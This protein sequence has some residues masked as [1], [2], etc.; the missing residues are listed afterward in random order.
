MGL[1][2][3]TWKSEKS[4]LVSQMPDLGLEGFDFGYKSLDL[5]SERSE[6]STFGSEV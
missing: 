4:D 1:R 5:G 3:L 2:G 6:K